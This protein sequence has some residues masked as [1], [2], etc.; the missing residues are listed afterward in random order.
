MDKSGQ[1]GSD[2]QVPQPGTKTTNTQ[3]QGQSLLDRARRGTAPQAGQVS[4]QSTQM[5]GTTTF[6][7]WASI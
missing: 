2:Q 1:M 6:T 4:S 7:D 5:G 3:Q